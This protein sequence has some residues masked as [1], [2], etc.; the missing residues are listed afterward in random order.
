MILILKLFVCKY[1]AK[2]RRKLKLLH[3]WRKKSLAIVSI[4]FTTSHIVP[5]CMPSLA[6][7]Q[8]LYSICTV[9]VRF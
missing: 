5:Q 1:F 3:V 4:L 7:V 9:Y 6:Y 8:Y 2:L